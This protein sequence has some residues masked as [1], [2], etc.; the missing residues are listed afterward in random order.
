MFNKS[1][2]GFAT[3][4]LLIGS[5]L[6]AS[7]TL[8]GMSTFIF[9]NKQF[10]QITKSNWEV[11]DVTKLNALLLHDFDRA[12]LIK[13]RGSIVELYLPDGV[14]INYEFNSNKVTR[15]VKNN[16]VIF[17]EN[18]DSIIIAKEIILNSKDLVGNLLINIQIDGESLKY[19]Y[20]KQYPPAL[21]YKLQRNDQ[22]FN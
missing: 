5:A 7:I 4:E 10:N 21:T 12:S 13:S 17:F 8:I 15:K 16:E 3:M 1:I 22:Y 2:K 19:I 18:V 20:N 6:A 14:N 9:F 11:V